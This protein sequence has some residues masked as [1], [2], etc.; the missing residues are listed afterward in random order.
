[1]GKEQ[2]RYVFGQQACAQKVIDYP[3]PAI[4]QD[5]VSANLQKKS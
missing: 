3:T 1:M 2:M 5:A 4:K